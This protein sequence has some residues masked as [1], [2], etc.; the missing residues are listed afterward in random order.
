[1]SPALRGLLAV[2]LLVAACKGDEPVSDTWSGTGDACLS[3][4]DGA[5]PIHA[6]GIEPTACVLCHGGDPDALDI[7]TAHVQPP[8]DHAAIRG[9]GL[10]VAPDGYIKDFAPD[11]LDQLPLDY[12]RFVNPGDL[13]VADLTCGAAGCHE[14][15]VDTVKRSIMSTN[16][17]HY[18]PTRFLAGY[19]GVD[20]EY[21]T[22]VLTD[23]DC[24]PDAYPGSVCGL[25]PLVPPTS[26]AFDDAVAAD[27][28]ALV[29]QIAYDHYLAKSCD[30]CHAAGYPT[31]DKP[32]A[33]R[34][35]GCTSCHMIYGT[36][37]HYEGDDPA[38]P[39]GVPAYP[40]RHEI[41]AAIPTEQCATC[42]FQGGR[43][44]LLYRGVREAGFG[45]PPPNAEAWNP[46]AY[47]KANPSF[48]LSDEDTTNSIDETPPDVHYE[49]GLHCAD[50]HVGRDVHGDGRIYS[51]SKQQVDLRCEDCHGSAREPA[52]PDAEG[53]FRTAT[54]RVLPQLVVGDDGGVVLEGIDGG[55][56]PVTQVKTLLD[57]AAPGS[58]MHAAMGVDDEGWSH[59]DDLTCDTCHTSYNQY[60]LGCHVSMD[61]RFQQVDHQTG[62][63]SDGLVRGGREM[64]S[65]DRVLLGMAA[66]GRAQSVNPSQQV[67][68][69][70]IGRDGERIVGGT[71]P[72]KDGD[73]GVFRA[74]A[75]GQPNNGFHVFFQHTV[76]RYPSQYRPCATCHPTTDSAEERQRV[77][78][79][80]G[81]GTGEFLLEVPGG[82][83]IDALQFLSDD[84]QPI[85][86]WVHEGTGPLPADR[87]DRAM[88][89]F[90]DQLPGGTQ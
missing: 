38:V 8:A 57:G 87:R 78:G 13:R 89:V 36:Y 60:C 69:T 45:D 33:F 88:S 9:D 41:T 52:T 17:G 86:D 28:L 75:D 48:Y 25:E 70:V 51:T 55:R 79:V 1:V 27:D 90:L 66:D 34:S 73:V 71:H 15:M 77:R 37:G 76:A 20:A 72:D 80:Y 63:P 61:V 82:G 42:H 83:T 64:V 30:T 59:V 39:R 58:P 23:P 68:M 5:E 19:Q 11:Q 67:Q 85:T 26:D 49:A 6:E 35:T 81:F 32:H 22:T 18:M 4:H 10:P 14:G 50:C 3:C 54:G 2:T 74:T 62:L 24:D 56:H 47:G 43:I 40:A 53:R 46:G 84:G 21:G 44:G 12:V 65:L 16:A 7:E 31:N 29:E